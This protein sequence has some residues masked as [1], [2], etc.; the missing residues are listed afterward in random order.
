MITKDQLN[1]TLQLNKTPK[2]II[3]L[4]P[5][6]TEMLVNL[7]LE[8]S[9]IG[10]TK[11]CIY[12]EHLL[13]EKE[14]VGGTKQIH[15]E[16]I[17]TLKPDFILCNKEENT[18][19]IV[20][21]V[22]TISPTYV[23]DIFTIQDTLEV[24]KSIGKIC[25]IEI[26]AAKMIDE[27]L[28]KK[29]KFT[30]LIKNDIPK[31]VAYFIWANPYMVVGNTNF[32]DHLLHLNGFINVYNIEERYPQIKLSNLKETDYVFLSS[33]PFPFKEKHKQEIQKHTK[34]K[35]LFVS[36]EAFSWYG[37]RLTKAFDY[38][39]DLRKFIF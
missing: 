31:K 4:V 12:P 2:R 26:A 7:G 20:E 8:E 30:Q 18:K 19:E 39:T 5:S 29:E 38:F 24:I 10:I 35:I 37:S 15:L 11:F 16:K 23:S 22:E 3:C 17:K 32:I 6:L 28:F 9:I 14:I 1:R 34:A 36:G 27:I 13:K 25:N 33:E 21:Q